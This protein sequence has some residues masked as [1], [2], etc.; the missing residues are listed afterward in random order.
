MTLLITLSLR[1]ETPYLILRVNLDTQT[2]ILVDSKGAVKYPTYEISSG[3]PENETLVGNYLI[4]KMVV[5]GWSEEFKV[6]MPYL[7]GLINLETG[8]I[9][10]YGVHEGKVHKTN[11]PSSHGCIRQHPKDATA[12]FHLIE[13]VWKKNNHGVVVSITGTATKTF[14]KKLGN[15]FVYD[16]NGKPV[17]ILRNTQGNLPDSFFE[18]RR[19]LTLFYHHDKK[20]TTDRSFWKLGVEGV[21]DKVSVEEYEKRFGQHV[22]DPEEI[23]QLKKLQGEP[24]DKGTKKTANFPFVFK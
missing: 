17:K 23:K 15:L 3:K 14:S 5:D 13:P 9:K 21:E 8:E 11:L 4:T 10:G 12:V 7:M 16:T 19:L 6:K 20:P 1:A 2:A 18:N 22:D 24:K